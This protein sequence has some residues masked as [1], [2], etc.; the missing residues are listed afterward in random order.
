LIIASW[1]AGLKNQQAKSNR[2]RERRYTTF[3]VL[4]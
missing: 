1:M 2:N 4:W 3:V